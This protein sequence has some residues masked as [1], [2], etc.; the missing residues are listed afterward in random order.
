M[1]GFIIVCMLIASIA[2]RA[3]LSENSESSL[4]FLAGDSKIQWKNLDE[5]SIFN[6]QEVTITPPSLIKGQPINIRVDGRM[7]SDEK[8]RKIYIEAS[9]DGKLQPVPI[10]KLSDDVSIGDDYGFSYDASVPSFVPAGNF[11]IK[12]YLLNDAEERLASMN[13]WFTISS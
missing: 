12:L 6:I 3:E 10:K 2:C 7:L 8:V 9:L 13:V 1:K 4:T 11:D 5:G